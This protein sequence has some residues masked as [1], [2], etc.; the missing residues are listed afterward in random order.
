MTKWEMKWL[1][2]EMTRYTLFEIILKR[3]IFVQSIGKTVNDVVYLEGGASFIWFS[4]PQ[5]ILNKVEDCF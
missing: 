5:L 2:S 1:L 3:N 4:Q